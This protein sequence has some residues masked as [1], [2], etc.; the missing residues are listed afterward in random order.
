[1]EH[2]EIKTS[3]LWLADPA[4]VKLYMMNFGTT[5]ARAELAISATMQEHY[6]TLN[7]TSSLSPLE[8]ATNQRAFIEVWQDGKDAMDKSLKNSMKTGSRQI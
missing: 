7:G 5:K 8:L 4:E 3:S 2:L 6:K 1:M